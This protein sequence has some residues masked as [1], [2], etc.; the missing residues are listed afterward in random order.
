MNQTEPGPDRI[1]AL[2]T[3]QGE[4]VVMMSAVCEAVL[5]GSGQWVDAN[6]TECVTDMTDQL[7]NLMDVSLC[8]H[9]TV[10]SKQFHDQNFIETLLSLTFVLI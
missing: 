10:I 4:E 9:Y 5:D 1:E 8:Q 7:A 3:C 6:Y 2:G